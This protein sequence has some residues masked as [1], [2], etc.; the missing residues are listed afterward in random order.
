[1]TP[2]ARPASDR[3]LV[4]EAVAA[5]KAT[6]ELGVP[7]ST[8]RSWRRRDPEFAR[9]Y[10]EAQATAEAETAEAARDGAVPM[11]E[12]GEWERLLARACRRGSVPALRLWRETH[13]GAAVPAAGQVDELARLRALHARL[14]AQR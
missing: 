1:M 7:A 13:A 4:L 8:V 2:P 11:L 12:L 10:A 5:G 3:E 14:E 6:D 9:R